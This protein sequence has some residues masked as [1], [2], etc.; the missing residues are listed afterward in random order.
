MEGWKLEGY[1]TGIEFTKDNTVIRINIIIKNK[2]G[3]LFGVLMKRHQSDN[4][5]AAVM[6]EGSKLS[7]AK[8][9]SILGHSNEESTRATAK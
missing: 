8:T 5:L 9:Q 2:K 7:V 4:T 1:D 6:R 3:T